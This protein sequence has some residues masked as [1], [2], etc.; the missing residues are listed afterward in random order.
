MADASLLA[1]AAACYVRAGVPLDAVRCYRAAGS[2]RRAADIWARLGA[3]PEAARDYAAAG[4]HEEAAWIFADHLG[5][6]PAARAELAAA[7]DAA[8]AAAPADPGTAQPAASRAADLRRRLIL[9]RC[10]AAE[11]V[12]GAETL[13]ILTEV[14]RH[15][16][17]E[18]EPLGRA[19]IELRAVVVAEA[20]NRPDLVALLFA[21][22]VR[23][24]RPRA[25]ERWN[26]WS[27]RALGM[28][29]ILPEPGTDAAV[30]DDGTVQRAGPRPVRS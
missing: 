28:P 26:A 17:D 12:A 25:A 3:F 4:A 16:E 5:D 7:A 24:G 18:V 9:A 29:L 27:E 11:N 1:R 19:S 20:M 14:M 6:I 23:G 30:A 15:L 22:A 2:Y 13:A 21:A 10:N 8:A